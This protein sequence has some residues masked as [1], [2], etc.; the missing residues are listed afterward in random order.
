MSPDIMNQFLKELSKDM[1][2]QLE[3]LTYE[4]LIDRLPK[5][6]SAV[7]ILEELPLWNSTE[8]PV[9]N[10]AD[11]VSLDVFQEEWMN[12][13]ETPKNTQNVT[14]NQPTEVHETVLTRELKGGYADGRYI[15]ESIIRR[16]NL[17]H[18]DIIRVTDNKGK[19]YVK[20]IKK[21]PMIPR[22]NRVQ[23]N[24]CHVEE[25]HGQ[26]IIQSYYK[27]S[28]ELEPLPIEAI[29]LPYDEGKELGKG[30]L[31][32]IAFFTQHPNNV[33]VIWK[34]E[35]TMFSDAAP[36]PSSI[37]KK[38]LP[39]SSSDNTLAAVYPELNNKKVLVIGGDDRHADYRDSIE[40]CGGEFTGL[41]GN[42][43][44]DVLKTYIRKSNVVVIIITA[45]RTHTGEISGPICKELQIPYTRVHNDGVAS[46]LRAAAN[47]RS[48]GIMNI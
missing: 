4:N 19:P 11:V 17:D 48:E 30:A 39:S 8:N 13:N 43:T 16:L 44:K 22:Q 12:K 35:T 15:G 1:M 34:H 26:F 33:S 6:R 20:I 46:I 36:L 40:A 47:P 38:S 41:K 31:V 21:G 42:A 7:S 32:D 3:D 45:S 5:L 2:L 10:E 37:N 9:E 18:N 28:S 25:I 27:N 29:T 14:F 23:F 24:L